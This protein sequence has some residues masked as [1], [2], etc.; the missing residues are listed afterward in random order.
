MPHLHPCNCLQVQRNA[1][2]RNKQTNEPRASDEYSDPNSQERKRKAAFLSQQPVVRWH[3]NNHQLGSRPRPRA[4]RRRRRG[5]HQSQSKAYFGLVV[6][7]ACLLGHCNLFSALLPL[8]LPGLQFLCTAYLHLRLHLPLNPD[9]PD[10]TRTDRQGN[11]NSNV[12]AAQRRQAQRPWERVE[13]NTSR[14]GIVEYYSS[15]QKS[16]ILQIFSAARLIIPITISFS[17]TYGL[18]A[19]CSA[20]IIIIIFLL[21]LL[22]Y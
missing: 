10:D 4:R 2:H 12:L 22:Y 11:H 1:R 3:A 17:P 13:R 19:C 16:R 5:N 21:I 15:G 6:T 14:I 18:V 9:D 8:P 20:S 7:F